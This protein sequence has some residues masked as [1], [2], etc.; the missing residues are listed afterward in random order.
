MILALRF[1]AALLAGALAACAPPAP[2]P[3]A[4][5]P[6]PPVD[7]SDAPLPAPP[8]ADSS[9]A[10]EP[11]PP[12]P[13]KLVVIT[14]HGPDSGPPPRIHFATGSHKVTPEGEAELSRVSDVL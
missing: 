11:P 3:L 7:Q 5:P 2:A 10:A 12:P 14:G 6:L 1:V 9:P 8:T 4:S 13:P